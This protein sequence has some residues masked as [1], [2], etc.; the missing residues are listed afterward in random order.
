MKESS[1]EPTNDDMDHAHSSGVDANADAD[2][3]DTKRY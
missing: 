2:P 3:G 1:L